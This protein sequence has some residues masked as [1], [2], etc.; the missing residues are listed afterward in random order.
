MTETIAGRSDRFGTRMGFDVTP[1]SARETGKP[2]QPGAH[3]L[4]PRK[5]AVVL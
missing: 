3:A 1:D 2:A 4:L 5:S